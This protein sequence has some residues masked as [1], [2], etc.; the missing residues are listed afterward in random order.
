MR[1]PD[2]NWMEIKRAN[3]KK[4]TG[5]ITEKNKFDKT[6]SPIGNTQREKK[7]TIFKFLGKYSQ[8]VKN[9]SWLCIRSNERI[10]LTE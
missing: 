10:E 9:N 6:M 8:F 4:F 3:L 5:N 7:E 2:T 1:K